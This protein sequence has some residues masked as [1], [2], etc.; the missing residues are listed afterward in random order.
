MRL[1]KGRLTLMVAVAGAVLAISSVPAPL[2][3]QS[4]AMRVAIPFDFHVGAKTL[5][6][7]TYIVQ[8][9]GDALQISDS[10]GHSAYVLSTAV[11]NPAAKTDNQLVFSRYGEESFLSEVRWFGYSDARG[12]IKTTNEIALAK[13]FSGNNVLSAGL[14]K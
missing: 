1:A 3:A 11:K 12:V 2:A 4:V 9:Q 5:P 8:K 7:G 10:S 13:A 6:A 14:T